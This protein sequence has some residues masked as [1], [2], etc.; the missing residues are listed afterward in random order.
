MTREIITD[1]TT[2]SKNTDNVIIIAVHEFTV[3]RHRLHSL[4]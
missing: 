3:Q 4:R 2:A 1:I